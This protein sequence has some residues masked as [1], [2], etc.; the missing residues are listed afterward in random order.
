LAALFNDGLFIELYDPVFVIRNLL[1]KMVAK[2]PEVDLK[3]L[4]HSSRQPPKA[5]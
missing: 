2:I 3:R 4:Q 5:N 1:A